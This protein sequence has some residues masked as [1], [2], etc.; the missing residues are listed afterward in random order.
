MS[1]KT[2]RQVIEVNLFGVVNV[3]KAFLPLLKKT[4][5]ARIVNLSSVAGFMPAPLMAAY[6]ASKHGVEGYAKALRLEMKPWNIH[7][8]NVNPGF[9]RCVI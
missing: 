3:I 5:G 1:S 8:S 4:Q 6:D 7:V 9:M 2:F